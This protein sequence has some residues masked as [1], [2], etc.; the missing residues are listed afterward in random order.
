MSTNVVAGWNMPGYMPDSEPADFDSFAAATGYIV[1]EL[2]NVIESLYTSGALDASAS[3]ADR[4]AALEEEA[5]LKR[6]I[7][8]AQKQ[9]GEFGFTTGKYHYFVSIAS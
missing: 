7:E 5:E 9:T 2:N 4:E 3:E 6:A 1:E 8:Y